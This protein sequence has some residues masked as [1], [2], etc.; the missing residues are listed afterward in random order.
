MP[1][2]Y[3]VTKIKT[4]LGSGEKEQFIARPC[5]REIADFRLIARKISGF[6][7]LS[8]PDI[9]AVLD[10]LGII[11]PELL[12][13]NYNIHLPSLGIFPASFKSK[14]HDDPEKVSHH[15]IN[16]IRVQFKPDK[17]ILDALKTLKIEKA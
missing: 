6:T 14:T 8:S 10:A 5:K 16:E 17:Q 9:I 12:E 2:K 4:R 15:S 7:T 1:I 13:E 11:I 3:K